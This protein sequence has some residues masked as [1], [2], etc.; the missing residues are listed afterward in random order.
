MTYDLYIGDF[1]YSS[2]S[3][4]G[5]LLF[6]HLGLKPNLHL[7]DFSTSSVADQIPDMAPARTV[8]C[9]RTPEGTPVWESLAMAE[10]LHDRH[11]DGGLWPSDPTA[12]ALGRALAAEMNAG[13][14]AL[15]TECPMN[16]RT[17]YRAVDLSDD[18]RADIAR[19]EKIWSFARNKYADQG[20]WL[21]GTYSIAD[22][23]YAP[24]AARFAGYDVALSDTAQAYVDTHLN[25]TM[26]RQ[27]RTMSLVTGK[28]LPWYAKPFDT[29][30]WPG[31]TPQPAKPV[32]TG[33]SVNA[34]CPFTGGT[35]AWFLEYKGQI[36]GF[37]NK[38]CRDET[39]QDPEAWPAF[40]AIT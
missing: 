17:A 22:I 16:L 15:R 34:T 40:I 8:P 19:I 25:D 32:E 18:T 29:K 33:P 14:S 20:P 2:W 31:P 9:M 38:L 10:E 7:V 30:P 26:F 39:V 12:R 5:W 4:R 37:E 3:L 6:R 36:Y 35:P 11:P 28:T 21:L 24:V 1:A 23:A 27:W 13:F